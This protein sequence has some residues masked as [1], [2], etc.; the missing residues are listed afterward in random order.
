MTVQF[1]KEQNKRDQILLSLFDR[2]KSLLPLA[3]KVAD[4]VV[5]EETAHL[6]NIIVQ[7]FEVMQRVTEYMRD[8]IRHG[9]FGRQSPFPYF[10]CADD[11][12]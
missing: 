3:E 7:M 8:Y 1:L 4:E 5:C 6:E 10:A 11:L 12:Q 2:L 9:R